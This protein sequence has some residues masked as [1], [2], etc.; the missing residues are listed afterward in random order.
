MRASDSGIMPRPLSL[1]AALIGAASALTLSPSRSR[2][3]SDGA[4]A[5]TLDDALARRR[6]VR[7]FSSRELTPHEIGRLAWA[8]QGIS[9]ASSG[10]RTAPSAGALYPIELYVVGP[11]G[12]FHYVPEKNALER[13]GAGDRRA[14]LARAAHDQEAVRRAGVDLVFAGVPARTA[15]KY[16]AR[17]ERYVLLEAGHAAQNVLLE[18][19]ALGLGAVPIGA[20]DDTEVS[21]AVGLAPGE[22]ALYVVAVGAVAR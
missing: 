19:V 14:Q 17:A 21:R 9:D 2:E 15:R 11:D 10:G 22:D 12:V 4:G 6:S 16:G 5:T 8:A 18:A 13:S 3:A 20:F 7:S 1:A